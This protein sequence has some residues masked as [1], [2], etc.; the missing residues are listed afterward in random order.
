MG[1]GKVGLENDVALLLCGAGDLLHVLNFRPSREAQ[2]S[3]LGRVLVYVAMRIYLR[4]LGVEASDPAGSTF[5]WTLQETT[6]KSQESGALTWFKTLR[7]PPS[8]IRLLSCVDLDR[9]GLLS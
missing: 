1:S 9:A 5:A 2:A 7:P 6:F 3:I 4:C 8:G